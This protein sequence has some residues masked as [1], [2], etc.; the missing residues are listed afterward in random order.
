MIDLSKKMFWYR[1]Q[2]IITLKH[3]KH[4]QPS[5]IEPKQTKIPHQLLY[6]LLSIFPL[7]SSQWILCARKKVRYKREHLWYDPFY[8]YPFFRNSHCFRNK[9][10]YTRYLHK[11]SKHFNLKFLETSLC[12]NDYIDITCFQSKYKKDSRKMQ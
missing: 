3:Q 9:T 2:T 10:L 4:W 1:R 5:V 11:I 12:W 6:V 8:F 7:Y